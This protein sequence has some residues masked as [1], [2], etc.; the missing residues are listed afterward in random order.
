MTNRYSAGEAVWRDPEQE[1]A[2]RATKVLLL[3][4]SGVAVMGHWAHWAIAWAPLPKIPP[5]LKARLS[6]IQDVMAG[7]EIE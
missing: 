4:P 7:G 2:P 6:R 1:P 5:A 3:N